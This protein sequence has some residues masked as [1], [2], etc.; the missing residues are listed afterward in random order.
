M[1]I[2]IT[3]G[4]LASWPM[5]LSAGGQDE[6]P[7][8]VKSSTTA[9]G[10]AWAGRMKAMIAQFPTARDHRAG[11]GVGR[12]D[13]GYDRADSN[14]SGPARNQIVSSHRPFH[15]LNHPYFYGPPP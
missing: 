3:D 10:S 2:A 11:I 4:S 12:T 9:R 7:C 15:S 8:E 5:I 6:Q 13:D 1:L 14:L